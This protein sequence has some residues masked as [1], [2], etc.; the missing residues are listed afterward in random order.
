MAYFKFR[1]HFLL[2]IHWQLCYLHN[3]KEHEEKDLQKYSMISTPY[4]QFVSYVV[5][6]KVQSMLL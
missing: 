6:K 5:T 2:H 1:V 3:R 4:Y